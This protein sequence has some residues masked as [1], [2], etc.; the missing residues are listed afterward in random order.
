MV[1]PSA[2]DGLNQARSPR[3]REAMTMDIIGRHVSELSGYAPAVPTPF[4]NDGNVDSAAFE[5][6]CHR[7]IHQGATAL[8]V[9]GTTGEAPTLDRAEHGVLIRLAV[10]VAR[11]RI[12]ARIIRGDTPEIVRAVKLC[13]IEENPVFA[14]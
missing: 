2:R 1:W 13:E 14:M 8:V 10:G 3:S 9:C 6:F 12:S 11:G 4:D 5:Q 7:Q